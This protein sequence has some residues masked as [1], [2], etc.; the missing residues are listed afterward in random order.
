MGMGPLWVP[1]NTSPR[2]RVQSLPEFDGWNIWEWLRDVVLPSNLK[3][4]WQEKM[5]VGR[6]PHPVGWWSVHGRSDIE[7][8]PYLGQRWR[9]CDPNIEGKPCGNK[10][11]IWGY[12]LLH[13]TYLKNKIIKIRSTLFKMSSHSKFLLWNLN[14]S[15]KKKK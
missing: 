14:S 12:V 8:V 6:R 3:V 2:P 7:I 9:R 10:A 1:H 13:R 11:I 5:G 4:G 15:P